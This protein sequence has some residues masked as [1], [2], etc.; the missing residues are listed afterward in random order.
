[1]NLP[2]LLRKEAVPTRAA[3]CVIEE[4]MAEFSN[5][6]GSNLPKAIFP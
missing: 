4:V 5:S 6:S 3:F 1:M 2:A